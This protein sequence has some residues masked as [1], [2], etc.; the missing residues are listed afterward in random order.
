[1]ELA[2]VRGMGVRLVGE[3]ASAPSAVLFRWLKRG[4]VVPIRGDFPEEGQLSA[5]L[6][7]SG[8]RIG[9]EARRT[10]PTRGP[11]RSQAALG[12]ACGGGHGAAELAGCPK[13]GECLGSIAASSPRLPEQAGAPAFPVLP[14]A[15][16]LLQSFPWQN[17]TSLSRGPRSLPWLADMGYRQP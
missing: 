13:V 5:G 15:C 1:M 4:A 2:L 10:R 6:E 3:G 14:A 17:G 8:C 12:S 9:E 16:P 7:G 11:G